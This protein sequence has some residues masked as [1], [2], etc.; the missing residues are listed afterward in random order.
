MR[1]GTDHPNTRAKLPD[2]ENWGASLCQ[3]PTCRLQILCSN[4]TTR[5]LRVLAFHSFYWY[6]IFMN[7]LPGPEADESITPARPLCPGTAGR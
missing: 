7:K 1:K 3:R 4:S 5:S 2:T 6:T